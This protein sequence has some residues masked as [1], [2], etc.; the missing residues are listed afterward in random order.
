MGKTLQRTVALGSLFALMLALGPA[1]AASAGVTRGRVAKFRPATKAVK[2]VN[3]KTGDVLRGQI[4]KAT[5]IKIRE[6]DGTRRLGDVNDVVFGAEVLSVDIE[7]DGDVDTIVL[8]ETGSGET[9]CSFD[10]S[11]DGDGEESSSDESWDCSFDYGIGGR[12]ESQDTSYDASF[13][14]DASGHS[15]DVSWDL[16]SDSTI[17]DDVDESFDCSFDA[18]ADASEDASGGDMSADTS[19]DCSWDGRGRVLEYSFFPGQ[20]AWTV[21]AAD[22]GETF[23]CRFD[24]E[25]KG[26][27]CSVDLSPDYVIDDVAP[28]GMACYSDGGG[29]YSCDYGYDGESGDASLDASLDVDTSPDGGSLS[30]DMSFDMAYDA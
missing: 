13:D 9:D 5:V 28:D 22:T 2:V 3:K 10:Y 21:T 24:A 8:D 17:G 30:G 14:A 6:D 7:H 15:M 16:S 25:T 12:D 26:W 29:S 18:S 20:L 1:E 23:G 11:T 4:S 19:F 27:D